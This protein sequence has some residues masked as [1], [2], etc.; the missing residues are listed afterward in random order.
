LN[1]H[2][3][4]DTGMGRI[5]V[6]YQDAAVLAVR[7]S[8]LKNIVIQGLFTHLSSADSNR[9]FTLKQI[10][11]FKSLAADLQK[12]GI[13]IPL[14]HAANSLGCLGYKESHGTMVR[15][16]LV[17]Y[18]LH[19]KKNIPI[20]LKPVLNLKTEVIYTKRVPAGTP[21]SYG[22][23]YLTKNKSVIATLPIGYGDGYPRNLS[24]R[25]PVLIKGK[26]FR[27]SGRVCMDQ[28][29]VDVG[30]TFVR[31]GDEV[32]LIGSQGKNT[33]TSEELASLS[34]TISY[35]I[36]CGLGNRIPRVYI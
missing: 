26:K 24:N 18:G 6:L 28:I 19:P 16:G 32:V 8:G 29:M 5:G 4:V 11:L 31:T 23:T 33:I 1:I 2:L 20:H 3:K 7:L 14:I 30:D 22:G 36:V 17:I 12:R 13:P 10:R 21:L 34:G 35:E 9:R 25:A 15:P 27:V